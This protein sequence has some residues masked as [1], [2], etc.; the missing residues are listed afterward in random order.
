[1]FYRPIG[2]PSQVGTTVNVSDCYQMCFRSFK[3]ENGKETHFKLYP[4]QITF[5]HVSKGH[6]C[7][8]VGSPRPRRETIIG[9]L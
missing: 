6:A 3:Q 5:K 1:M 9:I 2:H 7:T 4:F 8:Y